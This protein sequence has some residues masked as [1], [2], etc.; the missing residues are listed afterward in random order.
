MYWPLTVARRLIPSALPPVQATP[1]GD[2]DVAA[3]AFTSSQPLETAVHL[4]PSPSQSHP[5][6]FVLLTPSTIYLY[7]T[8]PA[9]VVASLRRTT[10]SLEEYGANRKCWWRP[11]RFTDASETAEIVVETTNS[12]L[13]I[14][15]IRASDPSQ[16]YSYTAPGGSSKSKTA[17]V[18]TAKHLKAGF[19]AGPGEAHGA[20]S[21]GVGELREEESSSKIPSEDGRA[22]EIRLR[23][24]L[25]VDAGLSW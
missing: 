25:K 13:I 5:T 15:S 10:T 12:Y 17:P 18:P 3:A 14:Y 4:S 6:H 19:A 21:A 16:A 1:D 9:Q 8:R 20:W 23:L 24:V 22:L 11:I 7:T 2:D